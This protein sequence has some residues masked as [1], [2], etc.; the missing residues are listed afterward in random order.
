MI[1][2]PGA[3]MPKTSPAQIGDGR[4]TR[5]L[6]N[7]RRIINAM[8]ELV[9]DGVVAPRAEEV[10][11]RAGVGLR[12]VFRHFDDME[13]LY[14]EMAAAME[15]ELKP[16]VAAPLAASDLKGKL[17]EMIER[18]ARLFERA[19]PFKD[20]AD[21]HRHHSPFL[22]RNFAMR[23]DE[24]RAA[25]AAVFSPSALHDKTILDAL[26]LVMSFTAWQHLRRDQ[27]LSPSG[28]RRA[29]ASAV[30]ALATTVAESES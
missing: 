9:R 4:K 17:N 22:R 12:T 7:T 30:A 2:S 16:L 21:I 27:K 29:V 23:R 26:D 13:T 3:S 11:T 8:L 18:R 28:A 10:A 6:N 5:R 19:L 25:V 14:R 24:E 15:R 20:A 1:S